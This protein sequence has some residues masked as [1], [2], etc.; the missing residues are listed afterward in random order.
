MN[1]LSLTGVQLSFL[2]YERFMLAAVRGDRKQSVKDCSVTVTA[3]QELV[4]KLHSQVGWYYDKTE[5]KTAE[6]WGD[7]ARHSKSLMDCC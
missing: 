1:T 5:H 6:L 7:S 2:F 4:V 3:Q